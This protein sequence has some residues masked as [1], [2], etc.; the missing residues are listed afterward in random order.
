MRKIKAV[1]FDLD[2]T[3]GN[4]IPLCIEAFRKSIEPLIGKKLSDQEITSTFGP[5]E[6]G[7]IK[8]LVSDDS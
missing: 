4:T 8:V 3:L 2:G 7:T 5:S 6:E 1:I